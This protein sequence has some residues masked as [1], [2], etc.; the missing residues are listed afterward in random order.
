MLKKNAEMFQDN[1]RYEGMSTFYNYVLKIWRICNTNI[2]KCGIITIVKSITEVMWFMLNDDE[3]YSNH[4]L[5][6][7]FSAS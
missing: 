6:F 4:I 1:E 2:F 3:L 5:D 7:F